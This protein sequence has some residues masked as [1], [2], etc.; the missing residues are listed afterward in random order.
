MP[1]RL[2]LFVVA[3]FLASAAVVVGV[4]MLSTPA[5]WIVGGVLFGVLSW[6]AL[7][8]DEA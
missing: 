7:S 4:S 1:S 5:A 2:V 3:L 8:G 6:L